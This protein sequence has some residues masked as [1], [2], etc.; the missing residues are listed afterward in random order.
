MN[1]T[2][3]TSARLKQLPRIPVRPF[4]EDFLNAMNATRDMRNM[5]RY[6]CLHP[7]LTAFY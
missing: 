2:C 5:F 4:Y 7:H 3:V 1:S 6:V